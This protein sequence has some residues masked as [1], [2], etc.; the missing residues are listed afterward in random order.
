VLG[1]ANQVLFPVGDD[2]VVIGV[3]RFRFSRRGIFFTSTDCTGQAYLEARSLFLESAVTVPGS[4]LY[5]ENGPVQAISA[6]SEFRESE[7]V[8]RVRTREMNA[9]PVSPV[10]D[11]DSLYT[12][13]FSIA[14]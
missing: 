8:C 10:V 6:E 13:P 1:P 4:T 9:V 11:L 3:T 5:V 7:Q 2:Q 14:R 12:A